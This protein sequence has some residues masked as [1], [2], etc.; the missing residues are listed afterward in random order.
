MMRA[1]LEKSGMSNEK[2]RTFSD[3]FFEKMQTKMTSQF[4]VLLEMLMPVYDKYYTNEDLEGLI[5]FYGTPLGQKMLK[6][7]PDVMRESQSIGFQW[8]SKIGQDTEREVLAEH[9]ELRSRRHR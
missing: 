6:N 4:G 2:A 5:A 3:L 7:S 9:P 8:G 1:G